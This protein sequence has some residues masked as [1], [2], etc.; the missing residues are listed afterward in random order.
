MA[1]EE[2]K[3]VPYSFSLQPLTESVDSRNSTSAASQKKEL[4]SF[5][6]KLYLKE[7]LFL[8]LTSI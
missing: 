2:E 3:S 1:A 8:M 6:L 4:G 7:T 5:K